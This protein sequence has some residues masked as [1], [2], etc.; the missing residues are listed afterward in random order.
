MTHPNGE[1]LEC[2][3]RTLNLCDGERLKFRLTRPPCGCA[4][5]YKQLIEEKQCQDQQLSWRRPLGQQAASAR[6]DDQCTPE[7]L[8]E[9][10][11][12]GLDLLGI[13]DSDDQ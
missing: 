5:V 2:V 9:W 12:Q 3:L 11:G 4:L 1:D 7:P 10:T 6:S 13:L 8:A